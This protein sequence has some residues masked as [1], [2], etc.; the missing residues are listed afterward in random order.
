MSSFYFITSFTLIIL[1]GGCSTRG[2]PS[3]TKRTNQQLHINLQDNKNIT[4]ALYKEYNKW[5]G[6]PYKYGGE[7]LNGVDCSSFIQTVYRDAFGLKLP[8][9][10]K[11]Q[12]KVGYKIKRYNSKSGDLI[13]FKT[14]YD[15]RHTG[16]IIEK[17]KFM[18]TSSKNGVSISSIHN[19]YWKSKYW[20]IKRVLP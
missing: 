5:R 14:A 9:T 12:A 11:N 20:K 13:F 19:P 8:R 15:T 2:N 1:L 17:D 16:I 6:T 18:H 3:Y 7:T 4:K 10:T